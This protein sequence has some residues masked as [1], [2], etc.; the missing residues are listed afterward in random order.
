MIAMFP[1]VNC[2]F[3]LPTSGPALAAVGMDRSGT[4]YI[5]KYVLNHSFQLPGILMVAIAVLSAFAIVQLF[6]I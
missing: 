1:A 5:G 2:L 6:V 4:T 3:I